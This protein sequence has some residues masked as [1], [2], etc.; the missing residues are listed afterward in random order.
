MDKKAYPAEDSSTKLINIDNEGK[1]RMDVYIGDE[2]SS[3]DLEESLFKNPFGELDLG[4]KRSLVHYKMYLYRRYLTDEKFRKS[5]HALEGKTLGCRCYPK[6]CHG[7]A[8]VDL[9]ESYDGSI[10]SVFDHIKSEVEDIDESDLGTKGFKE[11]EACMS[12]IQ[13]AGDN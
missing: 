9:I 5:V 10:K 3:Y 12:A 6:R 1:D 7:E 8:I 11:Y 13:E 2:N 4:K